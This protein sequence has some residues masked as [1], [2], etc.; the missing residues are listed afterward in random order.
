MNNLPPKPVPVRLALICLLGYIGSFFTYGQAG[1]SLSKPELH[2]ENGKLIIEY[3]I[4]GENPGDKFNVDLRITDSTGALIRAR[5]LSGDI[6]ADVGA[7]PD[8]RIIWDPKADQV[9]VNTGIYVEVKA[10]RMSPSGLAAAV[11]PGNA[12]TPG[13]N[14]DATG[15]GTG[16]ETKTT[17]PVSTEKTKAGHTGGTGKNLLLSAVVPGWGLTRM[18]GGKPWWIVAIVDAGCVG[19]AVYFDYKA[20]ES[21][22]K[23]LNSS[24]AA[25]FDVYYE[26]ASRQR[27]WSRT[28]GWSAAAVWLADMCLTG[29]RGIRTGKSTDQGYTSF[30]RIGSYYDHQTSAACFS[31]HFNF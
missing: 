22:D 14:N 6:G 10:G 7:G 17:P 21:Y 26:D 1:I 19:A 18:S 25:E 24:S 16:K 9:F 29:I 2:F 23:Y 11:P 3:S 12:V 13:K 8:K 4:L 5:N 28:F 31:V 15:A 27:T 20:T 30:I